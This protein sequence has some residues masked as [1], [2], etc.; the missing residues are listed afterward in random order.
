M[1]TSPKVWFV[2]NTMIVELADLRDGENGPFID[3]ATV[4]GEI[5]DSAG[6][7]VGSSFTLDPQ[8]NG[9]YQ[10]EVDE[11]TAIINR[12]QYKCVVTA[13]KDTAQAKWT[14]PFVGAPR[15]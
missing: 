7:A 6:V 11:S 2:D 9:L 15:T 3:D 13:T 8:T 4:E 12:K 10:A 5:F 14:I 1:V